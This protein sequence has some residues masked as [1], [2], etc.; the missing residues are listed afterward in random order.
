MGSGCNP[1]NINKSINPIS[2]DDVIYQGPPDVDLGICT[3]D[4]IT[5]VEQVI[6]NKL[7]SL[8]FDGKDITLNTLILDVCQDIKTLVGSQPK[9]VLTVIQALVQYSCTLKN[10][11]D[12]IQ[13]T[14][15][16]NLGSG[17]VNFKCV[18]APAQFS[19]T[20]ALQAIIDSHCA[21][22]ATVDALVSNTG[23][24][25]I[26]DG[27]INTALNNLITSV[28]GYGL[29]KTVNNTTG[30]VAYQITGLV[31]PFTALPYFGPLSNFD[32]S[33]KGVVGKMDGWYLCNGSNGTPDMR[34]FVPVGALQGIPGSVALSPIV[35][36]NTNSDASM[37][38]AIGGVG[39][40]AKRILTVANIPPHTHDVIDPGHIHSTQ[41]RAGISDN[42]NDRGVMESNGNQNTTRSTTGITLGITGGGQAFDNRM[43]YRACA[44]I[45]RFD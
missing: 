35:D 24:T 7:K 20:S 32:S 37:N 28:G 31:P 5:E 30:Q 34:G 40:S 2:S 8:V 13:N 18:T 19:Y 21:V 29:K 39:G 15:T 14:I 41:G 44:F 4:T 6:I 38:Y 26:I 22:K 9:T 17:T 36:P 43:P 27:R 1:R 42:A 16:G 3:G 45:M 11:I 10:R 33:G 25:T 23:N 12:S